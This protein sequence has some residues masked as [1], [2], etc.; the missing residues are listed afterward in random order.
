[1]GKR[2]RASGGRALSYLT[3]IDP[4]AGERPPPLPPRNTPSQPATSNNPTPPPPP[5]PAPPPPPPAAPHL[6]KPKTSGPP[7]IEELLK[8]KDKLRNPVV[9]KPKPKPVTPLDRPSQEQ[10]LNMLQHLKKPKPKPTTKPP[11]GDPSFNDLITQQLHSLKP[12]PPPKETTYLDLLNRMN[13]GATFD[14]SGSGSWRNHRCGG[15]SMKTRRKHPFLVKGSQ[16][17]KEYMRKLRSLRKK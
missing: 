10:I 3:Y 1:M 12:R 6:K 2:K 11:M 15:A 17:A 8:M 4:N 5:A 13:P 16:A 9:T 14:F 7:S